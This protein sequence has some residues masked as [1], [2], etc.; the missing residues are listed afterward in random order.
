MLNGGIF[1][2]SL[3]MDK[4][5]ELVGELVMGYALRWIVLVLGH[6]SLDFWQRQEREELEISF[7]VGICCSNEEL[8]DVISSTDHD[9]AER[10]P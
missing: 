10:T 8:D 4:G 9:S 5:D 3:A 2:G 1:G 6:E 7:H